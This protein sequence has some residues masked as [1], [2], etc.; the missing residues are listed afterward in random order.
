M[1]N[2]SLNN[3]KKRNLRLA[4]I[5][6]SLVNPE[7]VRIME[8]FHE[9]TSKSQLVKAAVLEYLENHP[10]YLEAHRKKGKPKSQNEEDV[11][12]LLREY[13]TLLDEGILTQEEF[14]AKKK[15]LL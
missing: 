11:L 8:I 3:W 15:E 1:T 6:L 9:V 4:T 13:K 7:D 2:E 14:E 12:H 5:Y 10:D